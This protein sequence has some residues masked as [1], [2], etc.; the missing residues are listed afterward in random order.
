VNG[1]S[2]RDYSPEL[3][4][5]AVERIRSWHE[6]AYRSLF[7]RTD[8]EVEY[9]GLRLCVPHG[10]FPPTPVSDLLGR[11]VQ[12]EVRP[13]DRVLDVGTGS[14]I[15]AILAAGSARDVVAV[16]INSLAVD[17]ARLNAE[18]NGV[19][20]RVQLLQSDLFEKVEGRF[21]LVIFDPPFRW[22]PARDALEAAITDEG[23]RTLG[24]FIEEVPARLRPGGRILLFFGSSGDLDYLLRL[25]DEAGLVREVVAERL[26]DARDQTVRYVTLR[27]RVVT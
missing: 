6:D 8:E 11:A 23:Y 5:E 12:A 22:F 2:T 4:P 27:L 17:C 21:D 16:D 10:V 7:E 24:R 1:R 26:L 9:L 3:P 19:Q 25:I 15:N 14:G 18:R 13:D 20:S